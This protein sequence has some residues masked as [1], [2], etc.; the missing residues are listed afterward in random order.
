SHI[1]SRQSDNLNPSL[2]P[3]RRFP[4]FDSIAF[5]VS[6]PGKSAKLPVFPTGIDRHPSPRQRGKKRVKVVDTIIEHEWGLARPEI[7]GVFVEQRPDG[8]SGSVRIT[9]APSKK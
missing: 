7:I 2:L 8:R 9:M 5:G 4:E 3:G 6:D 1:R